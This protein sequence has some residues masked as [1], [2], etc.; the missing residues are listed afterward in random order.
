[1]L[2]AMPGCLLRAAPDSRWSQA[3]RLQRTLAVGGLLLFLVIVVRSAWVSEDAYIVFR[4]VDNLANGHGLRWNVAE[5]VQAFTCPLWTLLLAPC[6]VLTHEAYLTC[7]VLSVVLA[8]VACGLLQRL[9]RSPL[10]LALAMAVLVS[11]KA[12]VDYSTSGLETALNHALIAWF[13]WLT[14][15]PEPALGWSAF[16]FALCLT[17]RLDDAPLLAPALVAVV[18]SRRGR[19]RVASLLLGLT[20]LVCWELFSLA[21]YG[22]PLPNTAYAK[23]GNGVG[24]GGLGLQG[25]YYLEDSLLRDPVTLPA[26]AAGVLVGLSAAHARRRALAAGCL[27]QLAYVVLIGGDF[28]SGRLLC[29]VLVVAVALLAGSNWPAPSWRTAALPAVPVLASLLCAGTPLLSDEG[30]GTSHRIEPSM[31]HGVAD[32]RALFYPQTGLLR[33]GARPA[34]HPLLDQGRWARQ[35]GVPLVVKGNVGFFGYEAGPAVHVVD[36]LAL[37]DAFLA[38]LPPWRRDKWRIGH[39]DRPIPEG[40]LESLRANQP[41]LAD[42]RL[43][44]Q[45]ADILLV[46]RGPL[47][48]ARRWAAIWRLNTASAKGSLAR[49]VLDARD[50]LRRSAAE[51]RALPADLC[52]YVGPAG[53]EVGLGERGSLQALGVWLD[54]DDQYLLRLYRGE[55]L[56]AEQIVGPPGLP[57]QLGL[58]FYSLRVPPAA[59]AGDRLVVAPTEANDGA[60]CVGRLVLFPP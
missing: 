52:L 10:P 9:A 48:A 26:V 56:L 1:M 39:F 11:S 31:R 44:R 28:M 32:E 42:P 20:P 55:Q 51:L 6:Y 15:R 35:A 53:L 17:N 60:C 47:F 33:V 24:C 45:F 40:Y 2:A 27:L 41:L 36:P 21:Y 29:P 34:R 7:L 5:R 23:L 57:L 19:P 13:C 3:M 25:L 54:G 18:L 14:L 59:A 43:A 16:V 46:T 50:P 4:V 37:T 49:A 38:R 8:A 12:L 22:F 30:Y 58:T